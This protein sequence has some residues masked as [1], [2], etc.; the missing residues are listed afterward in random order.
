[1]SEKKDGSPTILMFELDDDTRPL[2]KH[3]LHSRG[4]RVIEALEEE[5][6][7]ALARGERDR[8][9]LILLNQVDLSIDE[10]INMGRR[11]RQGAELPSYTPVV[12]TAERYGADM[13]GKDVKVGESEYVIY[14]EDGEQLMNLLHRLCPV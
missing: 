8:P 5:D 4:Y 10:F 14:L 11:I 9:D 6:A 1:M 7:I 3:N 2:L 13:E 12:V